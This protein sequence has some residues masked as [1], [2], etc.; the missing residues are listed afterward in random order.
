[1]QQA[2]CTVSVHFYTHEVKQAAESLIKKETLKNDH[3]L[4]LDTCPSRLKSMLM[5]DILEILFI[6]HH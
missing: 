1:M 2:T 6:R 4:I 5:T 3:F